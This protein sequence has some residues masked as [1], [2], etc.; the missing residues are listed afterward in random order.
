MHLKVVYIYY[1]PHIDELTTVVVL[2]VGDDNRMHGMK[3]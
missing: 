1:E 3:I 2:H